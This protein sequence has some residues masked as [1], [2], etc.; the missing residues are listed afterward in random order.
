MDEN[1]PDL[2]DTNQEALETVLDSLD[3]LVYVADMQTHELLFLNAY[4]RAQCGEINN[5][6]CWQ[7]LQHN[8]KGPCS[9]CNNHRL[10]ERN[11]QPAPV[12]VWEFRNT[13]NQRW[14]QCRDQAIHWPDGR[15]VRLEIA[16]DITDIKDLQAQLTAARLRAEQLAHEDELTGLANRRALFT[17][18]QRVLEQA[19]RMQHPVA[20]ISLDADRF[21]Q[22][23]DQYGHA[24]GDA[25]LKALAQTLSKQTRPADVCA[26]L[27]GEEF[28]I[29]LPDTGLQAA[30]DLA[31]RLRQ[32]INSLCI[33]HDGFIVRLSCSFGVTVTEL[34][35]ASMDQLLNSADI[36]TY[37][38]KHNGR[39]R[40]EV[41]PVNQ[42]SPQE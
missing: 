14:Y 27:G 31:E 18:G 38:A 12:E 22:I 10:V 36:A 8:Q 5:R 17:L 39:D 30:R 1:T 21:K 4:G 35:A 25:V 41:E 7:A 11:G 37:R 32:A 6:K 16:T 33:A 28:A 40:I 9:F 23:N 26:R 15:L 29:L 19:R 24:G 42:I 13:R 3:A 20:L 34:G 2:R